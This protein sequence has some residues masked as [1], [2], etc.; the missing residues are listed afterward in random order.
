MLDFITKPWPWYVAGPLIG[1]MVPLLLIFGNKSFGVS[2]T[3]RHIC[4]M[5]VPMNIKYFKYDWKKEL[6]SLTFVLGV[7]VGGFIASNYLQGNEKVDISQETINDLMALGVTDFSSF[8]P[9][10]IFSWGEILSGV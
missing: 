10:D 5:C 1:L 3:L 9:K 4:A 8:L 6:W 2:S 7:C